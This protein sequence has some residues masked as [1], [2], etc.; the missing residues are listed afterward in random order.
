MKRRIFAALCCLFTGF[1]L[2][3]QTAKDPPEGASISRK[4]YAFS[5]L[6]AVYVRL[7]GMEDKNRNGT[8]DRGAGEGYEQFTEKY[9]GADIGFGA[10]GVTYG[11]ANGH[12][13]EPE[14]INHYYLNI[15]FKKPEETETIENEVGAYIYANN[16]PLVWLD[17]EQGTVMKAVNNVLGEGW[18]EQEVT[19]DEAVRMFRRAMEGMRIR[20]RTGDPARTGYYT[21]PEFVTRKAGYCFEV[22]QFGFWFFSELGINA[23]SVQ[24]ALTSSIQHEAVKLS[25]GKLVDYSGSSRKYNTPNNRWRLENPMQI[26]ALY[27]NTP[28]G[29]ENLSGDLIEKAII[30]DKYNLTYVV[31]LMHK[32]YST[33]QSD[34]EKI[35]SLGETSLQNTDIDKICS[36]SHFEAPRFKD[37]VKT[38]L[39]LLL[40]G[41]SMTNNQEE[42]DKIKALLNKYFPGDSAVRKAIYDYSFQR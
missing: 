8:I 1:S 32:E 33:G 35:I 4:L 6:G 17:D 20:G 3:A 13:E 28:A 5:P 29:R 26:L 19:E 14:I 11:A 10:N 9:G 37:K 21:L 25:S 36:A 42:F 41:Y 15:R 34:Y 16:I 40:A 7:L 2:S 23:V 30:C 18:N 12:L 38:M 24:A 39:L 27:Y 22:A 31:A